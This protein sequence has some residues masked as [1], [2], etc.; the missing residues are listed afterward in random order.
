MAIIDSSIAMGVKPMQI[1]SPMNALAQAMQLKQLQ[2]QGQMGEM[3]MQESQRGVAADN[4]LAQLLAG[5]KSGADVSTG[6]AS[7]GYGKQALDYTKQMQAAAKDK[8]AAEKEQ[9]SNTMT[10]LSLGAQLLGGVTDQASYDA[11]R[12]T[13]QANGLDVSRM[14]PNYD[15]AFVAQK[16]KEGLTVKEQL[17]QYWKQKG[18]D[19]PDA[20]ARLS[21]Q[22]AANGQ[23]ITMRGQD[24]TDARARESTAATMSKPFEVTGPDGAP[25][26]VQQNKQGQIVPVTGY[27]PK[28]AKDKPMTDAQSKAALFGSRMQ[29]A[30]EVL[31]SLA[32]AGTTTSIPGARAG[33]G[34]G[35]VLNTVSSAKQ[36]QLNQAKRDFVNAVLRRESGAV[37][38][39]GEFDNAE[40][41]YFP[42][43][44]DSKEVISQKKNNREI[45]MRGVQAEVPKGQRGVINE[46]IGGNPIDSLLDKYK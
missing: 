23:Q 27:S 39:D 25:V 30:N 26:L 22:T 5:G 1:E 13:A 11:A 19:T 7:Q 32:T 16:L 37:I 45:A 24:M 29:A 38:S 14:Q 33:F 34:V 41:Q 44:G 36:Q 3:Q 15:P 17:E 43:V 21:A 18:Y 35:A 9:L 8:A 40:K 12:A 6:L 31:D 10:K 20:N 46:I 4:A 28:S 42:Q 2:Q